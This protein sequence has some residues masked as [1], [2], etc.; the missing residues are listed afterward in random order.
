MKEIHANLTDN[1][2]RGIRS[3]PIMIDSIKKYKDFS[4]SRCTYFTVESDTP[5]PNWIINLEHLRIP[6]YLLGISGI[7]WKPLGDQLTFKSPDLVD[8]LFEAIERIPELYVDINDI[9]LPNFLFRPGSPKRGNVYRV[10]EKLFAE[11]YR[12]RQDQ[13]QQKKFLL[14]CEEAI[15]LISFSGI[16][17]KSFHEWEMN[18][19]AI[20]KNIYPKNKEF[21]LKWRD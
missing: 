18:Q 9:W 12:Y 6:F 1:T 17:T 10:A 21:A 15:R 19:I 5:S 11:A 3:I 13:I 14:Y 16:E 7:I 20:A 4:M 8:E 2:E